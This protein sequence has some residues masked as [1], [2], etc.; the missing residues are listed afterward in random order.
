[1][2]HQDAIEGHAAISKW[3]GS[4]YEPCACAVCQCE[5]K[6]GL[7]PG[8]ECTDVCQPCCDGCHQNTTE[9]EAW[10]AR[11]LSGPGNVCHMFVE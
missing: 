1:M 3:G 5:V 11:L 2:R 4:P 6:V 7:S 8:G 10:I 9:R